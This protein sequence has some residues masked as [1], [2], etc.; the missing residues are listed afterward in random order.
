[1]AL[2]E[3]SYSWDMI[4]DDTLQP[5]IQN[6]TN[7]SEIIQN[8]KSLFNISD[9]ELETIQSK[10]SS[11]TATGNEKKKIKT[12]SSFSSIELEEIKLLSKS[13]ELANQSVAR[14]KDICKGLGLPVSGT[15]P[16]LLQ[17]I[18]EKLQSE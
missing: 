18:Q 14:L 12:D 6:V 1:M 16:N 8:I 15:K 3:D 10:R 9:I 13:N 4:N 7:C 11:S 5:N 17:R 2:F